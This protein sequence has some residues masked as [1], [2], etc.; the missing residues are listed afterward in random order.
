M[1]KSDLV[2]SCLAFKYSI[3][4]SRSSPSNLYDGKPEST[5]MDDEKA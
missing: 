3:L 2:I 1:V 5:P 4:T